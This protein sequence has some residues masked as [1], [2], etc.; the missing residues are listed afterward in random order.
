MEIYA[1]GIDHQTP[2]PIREQAAYSR[3]KYDRAAAW[4][5]AELEGEFVILST[6]NRSEVYCASP[7]AVLPQL[8][9]FFA[10]FHEIPQ[11]HIVAYSGREAVCH[12][13]RLAAGLESLVVGETQIL[14]QV[15]D[16]YAAALRQGTGGRVLNRCFQAAVRVG[17]RVQSETAIGAGTVSVA[18]LGIE[19]LAAWAGGLAG[20]RALVIGSGDMGRLAARRLMRHGASVTVTSR[21]RH[22]AQQVQAAVEGVCVVPY[23]SRYVTAAQCGIVVSATASPHYTLTADGLRAAGVRPECVLLD[24][25]V[26]R[27]IEPS[28][29]QVARL[30]TIDDLAG[31]AACLREQ[32]AEAAQQ[33]QAI[34]EECAAEFREWLD[35]LDVLDDVRRLDQLARETLERQYTLGIQQLGLTGEREKK[36]LYTLLKSTV[37]S[38]SH[39]VI[40][41]VKMGRRLL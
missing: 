12:L 32:A 9:S 1:A 33:A 18:G 8:V 4:L 29:A 30:Y 17:K 40:E 35:S 34:V 25:A 41:A 3:E 38:V 31:P 37:H 2:V 13:M 5:R 7:K 10:S 27:D 24:L 22:H 16:A 36:I 20:K 6:C 15:K 26:P 28:A 19:Q 39:P 11:E 21:T 14:G 23:D